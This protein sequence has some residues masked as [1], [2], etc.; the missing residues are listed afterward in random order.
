MF[1]NRDDPFGIWREVYDKCPDWS[2][3]KPVLHMSFSE[4]KK[5]VKI[6]TRK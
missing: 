3:L 4:R 2:N 5:E 1:K 6:L